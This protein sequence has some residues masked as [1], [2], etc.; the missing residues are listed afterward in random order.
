MDATKPTAVCCTS[1]GFTFSPV[2]TATRKVVRT[3]NAKNASW[4]LE[5]SAR[6]RTAGAGYQE[7][8]RVAGSLS[9]GP[10]SRRRQQPPS[11]RRVREGCGVPASLPRSLKEGGPHLAAIF[12]LLL[13]Q[14]GNRG[15]GDAGL[16]RS[17]LAVRGKKKLGR[18]RRRGASQGWPRPR[19]RQPPCRTAAGGLRT[20]PPSQLPRERPAARHVLP[21]SG[22]PCPHC[23]PSWSRA[24]KLRGA[25]PRSGPRGN[26][27]PRLR[28][29]R[30]AK[31]TPSEA[32]LR[33]D[34]AKSAG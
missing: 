14:L 23:R 25:Y 31:N 34:R 13:Q 29:G 5:L 28:R 15:H 16:E 6:A 10:H 12:L 17:R 18:R 4:D 1:G 20:P 24:K 3:S 32:R 22:L 27:R 26:R 11:A 8:P 21:Q 19:L 7:Q 30:E 9:V 33:E 2:L